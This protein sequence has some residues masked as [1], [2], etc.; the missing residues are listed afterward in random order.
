MEK[1]FLKMEAIGYGWKTY[2]EN[3]LF[4]SGIVIFVSM[5]QYIP[6]YLSENLGMGEAGV[7]LLATLIRGFV[8]LGMIG[9]ALKIYRE[10]ETGFSEFFG[11]TGYL[12]TYLLTS[13]IYGGLVMLGTLILIVPGIY[14][15]T[16]LGF[17]G[18]FIV[19]RGNGIKEALKNSRKITEG[20]KMDIFLLWVSL[21]LINLLGALLM[22]IGLLITIPVSLMAVTYVY[23][24]LTD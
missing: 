3:A 5:L 16:S 11:N 20:Y 2:K 10:R 21:T 24:K 17:F 6:T 15:A 23:G 4:L 22:L 19:D 14:I 9:I 1:K 7:V 8:D 18:Y 12:L 13:I